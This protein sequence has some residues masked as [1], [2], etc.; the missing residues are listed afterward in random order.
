MTYML[1]GADGDEIGCGGCG[2]LLVGFASHLDV[3]VVGAPLDDRRA[4][5]RGGHVDLL[6]L[7]LLLEQKETLLIGQADHLVVGQRHECGHVALARLLAHA[8]GR[9]RLL[10]RA[11]VRAPLDVVHESVDARGWQVLLAHTGRKGAV[12]LVCVV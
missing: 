8:H 6:L 12:A 9:Q 2:G 11:H 10:E 3:I 1:V 7:L 5:G 4:D